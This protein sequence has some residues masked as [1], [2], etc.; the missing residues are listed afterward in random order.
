M[1]EAMVRKRANDVIFN[2]YA[3]IRNTPDFWLSLGPTD[4]DAVRRIH[5][6]MLQHR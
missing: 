4:P 1:P 5:H 6:L 3:A 2:A